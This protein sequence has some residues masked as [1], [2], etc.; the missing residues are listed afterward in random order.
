MVG[1]I[2]V[3]VNIYLFLY[4]LSLWLIWK[5]FETKIIISD[6]LVKFIFKKN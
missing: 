3:E 6:K 2:I 1:P 5:N 4:K